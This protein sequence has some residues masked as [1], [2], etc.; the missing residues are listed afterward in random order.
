MLEKC[1]LTGSYY[2]LFEYFIVD[3]MYHR[4]TSEDDQGDETGVDEYELALQNVLCKVMEGA[5]KEFEK[6]FYHF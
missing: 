4:C 3:I 6:M 2:L 5:A 1:M